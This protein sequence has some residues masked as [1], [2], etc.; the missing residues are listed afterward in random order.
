[1]S[2][3]LEL[4]KEARQMPYDLKKEYLLKQEETTLHKLILSLMNRLGKTSQLKLRMAE[5]STAE[6]WL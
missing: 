6:T 4:V 1:M 3:K 2:S 5:M